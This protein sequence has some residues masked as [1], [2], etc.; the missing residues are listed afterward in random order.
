MLHVYCAL[1]KHIFWYILL[2]SFVI[3][4]CFQYFHCEKSNFSYTHTHRDGDEHSLKNRQNHMWE[5]F[6][7]HAA[8]SLFTIE[9]CVCRLARIITCEAPDRLVCCYCCC[10]FVY[11]VYQQV[12]INRCMSDCTQHTIFAKRLE[13][14]RIGGSDIGPDRTHTYFELTNLR[15][16]NS[17]NSALSVESI[18]KHKRCLLMRW[19]CISSKCAMG[20]GMTTNRERV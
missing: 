20:N 4:V 9:L 18:E 14:Y 7:V 17:W 8:R 3:W 2:C 16:Y 13:L 5:S 19:N 1:C 11:S 12:V 10:W 6:C 15:I